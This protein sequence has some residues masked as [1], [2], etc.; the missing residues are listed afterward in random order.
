MK[1]ATFKTN[2]Q[3][4]PSLFP[5]DFGGFINQD[6]PVRI[7]NDVVN[8]LDINNILSTYPGGGASSFHPRMMIKVLVYAYL[9]N[10]YSS[11][12]IAKALKENVNFIWLS[13]QQFPDHRTINWFRGKKLKTEIDDIF[14]Q[15]VLL[16]QGEGLLTLEE[17]FTDG[18]K[19]ESVANRY[20]FVW[21]KSVERFKEN[22]EA[23]IQAVL[24]EI[25]HAIHEDT[26]SAEKEQQEEKVKIDSGKLHDKIK[27]INQHLNKGTAISKKTKKNIKDLTDKSLPKLME[28]ELKLSLL[29]GRNSYSKTDHQATFMRMKEDHMKNGQLKPAYN[30]QL[31]TEN[32]FITNYTL[33]QTP[34]DTTTF[35]E[36]M[37][38]FKD[39]YGQY[40]KRAI[41]DAGYGGLEN[42]DFLARHDID[43]FVKYNYFHKEQTN[44][45]KT[46]ISKIENLYYN[47]KEDCFICPMGQKMLALY[48]S[49]R[50]TRSTGYEYEATIYKAQNC[51]NCPLR[52]ACHKQKGDR[53]IEINKKL[54]KHK[55]IARGNLKS[56]EGIKLR[57][58]R[59]SEVEQT[60]G[61]IKWN[62]RFNRFLLKGLPKTS[63]EI[64]L[65]AIA[66]NMQ[67]LHKLLF[68]NPI[69]FIFSF[70]CLRISACKVEK[71][72]HNNKYRI[73]KNY[74]PKIINSFQTH[75]LWKK[76]QK[77]A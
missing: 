62:K 12:K 49:K 13:G 3:N 65:I 60:F 20:T 46:D 18:T 11:R 76:N 29:N 15:V 34:G 63:I 40:P 22:L 21:K 51:S 23:K 25:D 37:N 54:I 28:Y 55:Q 61:Q 75:V 53:Q 56:E 32:N 8:N 57:G 67:K 10:I 1:R 72:V 36:H 31:S 69:D 9:N 26:E 74:R 17:V 39:K 44:K 68:N 16:L 71:M 48:D 52:G 30:L 58:R 19:I 64:G 77:A 2:N 38:S 45:F 66:H 50:K 14:K 5:F 41:A 43:N 59:N 33:H 35:Q 70:F 42:Y 24:K 73:A 7:I 27:E 6:N 4:Q 47:E